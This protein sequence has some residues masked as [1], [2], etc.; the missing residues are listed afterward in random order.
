MKPPGP[1][2]LSEVDPP[3]RSRRRPSRY[4]PTRIAAISRQ[5]KNGK[6]LTDC[7]AYRSRSAAY[8]QAD[9]LFRYLD[10]GSL[11]RKTWSEADGFHWAIRQRREDRS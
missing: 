10:A 8:H 3:R 5:L 11:E 4:S 7:K 6:W 9:T 2:G 1:T